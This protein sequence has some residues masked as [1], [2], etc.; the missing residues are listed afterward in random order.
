[1]KTDFGRPRTLR[2]TRE[3]FPDGR[4]ASTVDMY[5]PPMKEVLK[6]ENVAAPKCAVDWAAWWT[7]PI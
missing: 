5:Y 1:M 6:G 2:L 3:M 7:R 4:S